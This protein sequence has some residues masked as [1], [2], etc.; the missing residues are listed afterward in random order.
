MQ[1]CLGGRDAKNN[2]YE[3]VYIESNNLLCIF[4]RRNYS[5]LLFDIRNYFNNDHTRTSDNLDILA[6]FKEFFW[7]TSRFSARRYR[8]RSIF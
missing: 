5:F 3:K 6:F 8:T 7:I 2:R 1:V 4:L